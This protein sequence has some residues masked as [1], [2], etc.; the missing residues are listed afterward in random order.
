MVLPQ[1][2]NFMVTFVFFY[3][4]WRL[5][6]H[7]TLLKNNCAFTSHAFEYPR[8]DSRFNDVFNKAMVNQTYLVVTKILES[9]KGFEGI[10]R[11]MDVGGGFGI[12]MNLIT[13]KY[14]HIQGVNF[15]QP[16]V[17]QHAPSY[18]SMS[19]TFLLIVKSL[20]FSTE[21]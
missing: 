7:L 6:L 10:T 11:V 4:G 2:R 18:P 8:V 9:Y 13:S 14:P 17:I 20:L 21:N 3:K 1:F 5:F 16:H 19:L 12:T 15:D